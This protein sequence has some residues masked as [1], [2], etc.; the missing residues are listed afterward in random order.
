MIGKYISHYKIVGKIGA[1]GMGIVYK[2]I[3]T[4]LKRNVAIKLLPPALNMDS[5]SSERF[6]HEAQAASALDHNNICT[7][8]EIDETKDGQTF[9]VMACY[10]GKTLKQIIDEGTLSVNKS[11]D[12]ITQIAKGLAKAHEKGIVHRDIKPS[13]IFITDEGVVKIIDFGLAKLTNMTRITKSGS[14]LGT[15]NYISPEQVLGKEVD[16]KTDIWSLGVLFYEM[17]SGRIPFRGEYEQAII[18][19]IIN[20]KIIP[21]ESIVPHVPKA[22]IDIVNGCLQKDREKRFTSVEEVLLKLKE[23]LNNDEI[24]GGRGQNYKNLYQN[25]LKSKILIPAI[26]VIIIIIITGIWLSNRRAKIKWARHE[27]IPEIRN[28]MSA[29]WWDYTDPYELARKAE[30]YI[31][32]D[33]ILAELISNC[34]FPIS[35]KTEPPGAKVFM[36]EYIHPESEWQ[37]LG[38][39]PLE[40][41]RLPIGIFRWKMELEGFDTVLA[42]ASTWDLD[43]QKN[44]PIVPNNIIRVLDKKGSIPADMVHVMGSRTRAGKINDFYMD[45]YEVTNRQY[46]KF[47][48]SGGYTKNEY[49]E[50]KFVKDDRIMTW[51]QAMAEFVDQTGQPGPANWVAGDYPDGHDNYPVSGISW[52]EAA[53][54]AKFI[55]KCLPTSNH[56]NLARG[57]Y[58]SLIRWPQ[59]GGFAVFAPFCNFDGEGT[60]PVGSYN[61]IT[62]FGAHDMAGNVREWCWNETNNG[63]IIRGGAWNDV[64]YMFGNLSQVPAFNRSLKNGFRCALYPEPKQVPDSVFRVINFQE[65]SDFYKAEPVSDQ[66]FRVYKEQFFYDS[67]D[68]NAKLEKRDISSEDWTYERISFNAAYGNERI[69]IHLFLPKN[70][71]AP[72]QTVI[73]FPGSSAKY[74][75]SSDDLENYYGF[76]VFMAP[77]VKTG[78]A[79]IYPVYKGTFE[80]R[81]ESTAKINWAETSHHHSRY[82]IQLVKDFKRCVDYCKIRKDLNHNK[83]AYYGLSWGGLLGP[84][85]SAVEERLITA[86]TVAGGLWGNGRPEVNQVNYIS[87]VKIPFLM[88]NG[89]YDSVFP[90][91]TS[92]KPMYDLLGTPDKHKKLIL[93]ETDHVPP[94][95]ELTRDAVTWLDNYLGEVR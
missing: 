92:I 94:R 49:W 55:G 60:V 3:D 82:V 47:I 5:E 21:L 30:K 36:K 52:Y 86:I 88:L 72:Y 95:N 80:R 64:T 67:T 23:Y 75:N 34:S 57:G 69:I 10:E 43:F 33:T 17:L 39:S 32:E 66:V 8:Y 18:Y 42:A 22:V 77:L 50:N 84:I 28:M 26:L 25:F 16:G 74:K 54:Y 40:N 51:N 53:A 2:A 6:I 27:A 62:S 31:P 41:I 38:V 70:T 24:E 56:W 81:D 65:R 11:I 78:R 12:I 29:I 61:G 83:I 7:I 91:E 58:T 59:L 20:R 89:K 85:I 76:Y 46:K 63:R 37:Y 93:Y 87:H 79:V 35:I 9:I 19:S 15:A 68:L 90:Y 45:K 13:N 1:G 48:D 71:D 4:K 73:Y 14:T 44:R